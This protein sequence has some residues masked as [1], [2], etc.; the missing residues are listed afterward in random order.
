MSFSNF[1][2]AVTRAIIVAGPARAQYQT[3]SDIRVVKQHHDIITR[4]VSMYRE[5][6]KNVFC[7]RKRPTA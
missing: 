1:Y 6:E 7:H 4:V 5:D 3:R 2:S